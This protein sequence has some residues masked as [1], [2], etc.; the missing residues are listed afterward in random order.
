M[1]DMSSQRTAQHTAQRPSQRT[2]SRSGFS[3]VRLVV[4]GDDFLND[5]AVRQLVGKGKQARPDAELI[6]LD[7]ATTDRYSFD[8][9]TGPSLLSSTSIVLVRNLQQADDA[10]ASAMAAY[11][12]QAN[13]HPEESSIVIAQHSGGNKGKRVVDALV[14]AGAL[15][16]S[17]PD[18]SK[19]E[20]K[21]NFVLQCFEEHR[22]RVE[23]LAAQQLVS[24]L[25]D[26]TGELAAMCAQL[27]FDFDDDPITLRI[28]DQYLVSNPQ[29]TSF[30]VADR[31]ME[32][33]TPAAIIAMRSAI[34]QGVDPIALIGALALKLRT[35]AK[36]SAVRSGLITQSE[37]KIHPWALKNAMRT[38]PHWTSQGLSECIQTL[39]WADE[40]S[41]TN[42]GDPVYALERSIELIGQR[43]RNNVANAT[44]GV[45]HGYAR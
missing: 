7:A 24:V 10:L 22:R 4:G 41:K 42:G 11:T 12:K 37:A 5:R 3:P 33:K 19:D 34:E 13:Q 35:V 31:A 39:A 8:E 27:C 23:P 21:L 36:A 17:V 14:K 43:G 6:E 45:H 16:E 38:L 26:S 30:A 25:G 32:G 1:E 15:R 20:A 28:V 44:V 18:L 9:A 29:V 40:Q 2:T